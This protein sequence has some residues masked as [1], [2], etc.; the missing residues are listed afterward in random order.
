MRLRDHRI[1]ERGRG[2]LSRE[3]FGNLLRME[4]EM[5]SGVVL[6]WFDQCQGA[7]GSRSDGGGGGEGDDAGVFLAGGEL[8]EAEL[9]EAV[10]AAED[11]AGVIRGVRVKGGI[12]KGGEGRR[13][14]GGRLRGR[15]WTRGRGAFRSPPW[16][17]RRDRG[18]NRRIRWRNP[19]AA[20]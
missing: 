4:G 5:F 6:R 10:A 11:L 18:C 20:P 2:W 16:T 12:V 15:L 14:E 3:K 7:E 13:R 1:L 8:V 17:R 9:V 19:P